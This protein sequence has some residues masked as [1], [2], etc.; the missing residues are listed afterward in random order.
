VRERL[1]RKR[2]RSDEF[3]NADRGE[4]KTRPIGKNRLIDRKRR[5][6]GEG[7]GTGK[8]GKGRNG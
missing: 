3:P 5:E 6:W 7:L 8:T 4:M 1:F 2:L